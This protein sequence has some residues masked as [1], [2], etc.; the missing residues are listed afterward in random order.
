VLI[1]GNNRLFIEDF[2]CREEN[3]VPGFA[4]VFKCSSHLSPS[5]QKRGSRPDALTTVASAL[6]ATS[7]GFP[8]ETLLEMMSVNGDLCE[9]E[10]DAGVAVCEERGS[11]LRKHCLLGGDPVVDLLA[12]TWGVASVHAW[13]KSAE[14]AEAGLVDRT[15]E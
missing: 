12:S 10:H 5:R 3:A 2:R 6:A 4:P 8:V 1:N 13:E 11:G 14:D 15:L 9:Y 7:T